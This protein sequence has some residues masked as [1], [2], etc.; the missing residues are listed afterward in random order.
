MNKKKFEEIVSYFSDK[1]PEDTCL[2]YSMWKGYE[3]KLASVREMLDCCKNV[4]RIHVSGH[5]T[6]EGL[7][8]VLRMVRPEKVI[9]HHTS[10]ELKN[11]CTFIFKDIK[12]ED[13]S[14]GEILVL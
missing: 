6:Q 11:D 3:E 4:E 12:R 8:E 14:D 13:I 7:E 2:I 9:I 5:V 10:E 1:Y